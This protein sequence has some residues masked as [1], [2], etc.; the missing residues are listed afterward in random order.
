M[1]SA[2]KK[3]L[4]SPHPSL[5]FRSLLSR[6]GCGLTGILAKVD[7]AKMFREHPMDDSQSG[8]RIAQRECDILTR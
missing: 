3:G 8:L 5:T 2:E 7:L 1:L 4:L 6:F